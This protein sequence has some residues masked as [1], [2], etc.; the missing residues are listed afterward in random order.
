MIADPMK[1]LCSLT[2]QQW[3]AE[4]V[5]AVAHLTKAVLA[6]VQQTYFAVDNSIASSTSSRPVGKRLTHLKVGQ[7]PDPFFL[8]RCNSYA[9]EWNV[10]CRGSV[11]ECYGNSRHA[12]TSKV[13]ERDSR[14][15]CRLCLRKQCNACDAECNQ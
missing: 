13:S 6:G 8:F 1:T 7:N 11:S 15:S 2:M 4:Y 12:E 9:R 3:T 10:V 14:W 5:A